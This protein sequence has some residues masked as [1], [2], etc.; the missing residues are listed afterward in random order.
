MSARK[1]SPARAA[2]P[3]PAQHG[4]RLPAPLMRGA[5]AFNR[6][7]SSALARSIVT[8]AILAIAAVLI[9][10][11]L[12]SA[13][14]ADIGGAIARTPLWAIGASAAFTVAT[15]LCEALVEWHALKFIGKPLKLG[16][17]ILAASAASAL[18]IAMGFGLASGTAARLRFYAFAKLSAA[19][20]A[21]ITALVSGAIYLTGMIVLGLSGL[22]APGVL[23][24]R[25]H[26][27]VWGVIL[28]SLALLAPAPAWFLVL[29]R[30]RGSDSKAFGVRGRAV[31]LAAGL[32]NWIFQGAAMFVL[33]V[34]PVG[35]FPAFLAAFGLGS[36]I[37][38][39]TGVPADLGVLEA[40]V[41]GSHALGPAHQGAAALVL[42]RVI[43]QLIPL[44]AA[45]TV[46]GVRQ[47]MGLA[48]KAK[49]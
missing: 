5:E 3:A 29:R 42:Y 13:R 21:K 43:F 38:S 34:H 49:G 20:V 11:E 25:L 27:P 19:D 48:G 22:G 44:I 9:H 8:V 45:T 6:L 10:G 16:R 1:A 37:G 31:T 41:L 18:S 33:A 17:T 15:Y 12:K 35:Q 32:G 30:W 47:V 36:L 2:C 26:W 24:A 40:T 23:A 7:A 46:M 28:L 14:L 39:L 4:A